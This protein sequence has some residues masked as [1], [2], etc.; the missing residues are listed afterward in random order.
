MQN[1][2]NDS[3]PTKEK[4]VK[5]ILW[6]VIG[7]NVVNKIRTNFGEGDKGYLRLGPI[8]NPLYFGYSNSKGIVYKLKLNA[9]YNFTDNSDISI[10]MKLGYSFKQKQLY[11]NFPLRYTFNKKSNGYIQA[12]FGT[13]NRISDSSVLEKV[14]MRMTKTLLILTNES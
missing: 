13:G 1:S 12:D 5:Y 6:D 2:G 7:D 4:K 3:V 10:Y 9:N 11:Y 8:F 14:K